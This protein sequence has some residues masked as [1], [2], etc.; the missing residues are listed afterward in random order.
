MSRRASAFGRISCSAPSAD[1]RQQKTENKKKGLI[2]M[3]IFRI[4]ALFLWWKRMIALAIDTAL[5]CCLSRGCLN[6]RAGAIRNG[7]AISTHTSARLHMRH[8]H[9]PTHTCASIARCLAAAASR[10]AARA[11]SACSRCS[12]SA[13]AAAAATLCGRSVRDGM[14]W[15]G[16]SNNGKTMGS[17]RVKET[18]TSHKQRV[19]RNQW[20]GSQI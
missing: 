10:L 2:E 1:V 20:K 7:L 18:E 11:A 19:E 6:A 14:V 16:W 8:H 5:E 15:V 4:L 13:S 12:R 3:A 17:I 9:H